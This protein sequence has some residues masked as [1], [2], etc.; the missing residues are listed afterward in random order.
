MPRGVYDRSKA[1][2]RAPKKIAVEEKVEVKA[3]AEAPKKKR[4]TKKSEPPVNYAVNPREHEE[5]IRSLDKTLT[6]KN[7][8]K[9]WLV[10]CPELD[11]IILETDD[12]Y[13]ACGTMSAA[14]CPDG[15]YF[16]MVFVN[17]NR[18]EKS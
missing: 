13:E 12:Y 16:Y 2:K 17:R 3:K 9:K 5:L 8:T 11:H 7:V 1:K 6:E 14:P 15:R 10:K 4:A 18:K